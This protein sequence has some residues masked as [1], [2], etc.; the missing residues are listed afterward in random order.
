MS[1]AGFRYL[2]FLVSLAWFPGHALLALPDIEA[3]YATALTAYEAKQYDA[4]LGKLEQ[5]L[6]LQPD[7][8]SVHHLMGKCYGRLAQQANPLKAYSL[9]QKTRLAFEKA[10]E[11]DDQNTSALRDLME[12]YRQAPG[13]LGGSKKKADEIEK[14]L[15]DI[16]AAGS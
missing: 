13:F 12:Y 3:L 6:A 16:D 11:L 14:L 10:V 15:R 5:A 1:K 8:S 4:A 2:A 9:T 7:S